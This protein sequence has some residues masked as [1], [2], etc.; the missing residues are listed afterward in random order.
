MTENGEGEWQNTL[1]RAGTLE[2]VVVD[3]VVAPAVQHHSL[4]DVHESIVCPAQKPPFWAVRR[5][6][7]QYEIVTERIATVQ[8]A[9]KTSPPRGRGKQALSARGF[10]CVGRHSEHAI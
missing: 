10:K 4:H 6:A 9:K 7:R 3:E 1:V 8:N 5:P 2:V